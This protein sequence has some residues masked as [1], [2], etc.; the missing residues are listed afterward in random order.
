MY[1]SREIC[2]GEFDNNK[3][4]N[5]LNSQLSAANGSFKN[6]NDNLQK[7]S[8]NMDSY[9]DVA[10]EIT[11]ASKTYGRTTVADNAEDV[12]NRQETSWWNFFS[13]G[14]KQM[15][16]FT[17]KMDYNEVDASSS[18]YYD[19][20]DHEY[21]TQFDVIEAKGKNTVQGPLRKATVQVSSYGKTLNF[22]SGDVKNKAEQA[23]KDDI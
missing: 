21:M 11:A 3:T 14:S 2:Q 22:A 18:T 6:I 23:K 16:N 1:E 15:D 20:I 9:K 5:K 8:E 19:A 7:I 10:D 17:D 4:L 12:L 13:A